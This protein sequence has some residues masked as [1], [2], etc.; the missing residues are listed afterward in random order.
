MEGE[1]YLVLL[2]LPRDSHVT[3]SYTEAVTVELVSHS[4]EAF[5][6]FLCSSQKLQIVISKLSQ[7][8]MEKF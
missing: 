2:L 7:T 3:S 6:I 5:F 8:K 4:E 1:L